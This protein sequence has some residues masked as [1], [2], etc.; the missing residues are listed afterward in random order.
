MRNSLP[1]FCRKCNCLFPRT[2]DIYSSRDNFNDG[3]GDNPAYEVTPQSSVASSTAY[4][5][6]DKGLQPNG[7]HISFTD[8]PSNGNLAKKG[9][10]NKAFGSKPLA[11]F[12]K[13][14]YRPEGDIPQKNLS[15]YTDTSGTGPMDTFGPQDN[16]SIERYDTPPESL[17]HN[18][19]P[20]HVYPVNAVPLGTDPNMNKIHDPLQRTSATPG[21]QDRP[22]EVGIPQTSGK[23]GPAVIPT[24]DIPEHVNPY[25]PSYAHKSP[26]DVGRQQP[27]NNHPGK[28]S[29]ARPYV[30]HPDY[31]HYG[32]LAPPFNVSADSII[33]MDLDELDDFF[34]R[35]KR[36]PEFG[37]IP[38]PDKIYTPMITKL[39]QPSALQQGRDIPID[40]PASFQ[41]ISTPAAPAKPSNHSAQRPNDSTVNTS[42][43]ARDTVQT[44]VDR[45]LQS[46]GS[47]Q[48]ASPMDTPTHRNYDPASSITSTPSHTR[49]MTP[50][51]DIVEMR[52]SSASPHLDNF[53]MG[54]KTFET[55]V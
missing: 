22:L 35:Q 7:K 33:Y 18:I 37:F 15:F 45:D 3:V 26:V 36:K 50:P 41:P 10:I 8:E 20:D 6:T 30:A 52:R 19:G 43:I 55:D 32:D 16:L 28:P 38:D 31:P 39:Y 14:K 12:R 29:V 51:Q 53:S 11:S 40:T 46:P 21:S 34:L 23:S 4:I 44:P 47:S 42:P 25:L 24:S 48:F 54:S 27:A 49:Y 17:E 2:E 9:F 13:H 5:T 1:Y